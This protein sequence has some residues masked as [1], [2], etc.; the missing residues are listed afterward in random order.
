MQKLIGGSNCQNAWKGNRIRLYTF[1]MHF[2]N[3]T[4]PYM[5]KQTAHKEQPVFIYSVDRVNYST[6]V[7]DWVT[8]VRV[9]LPK[10]SIE[11]EVDQVWLFFSEV[12]TS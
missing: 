9:V 12:S 6:R 2:R 4:S 3:S 1:R 8:S 11:K 5:K 7:I 10:N